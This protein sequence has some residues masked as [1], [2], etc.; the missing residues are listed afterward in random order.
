[1]Q[2]FPPS[3]QNDP[4]VVW[5]LVV[6]AME[7]RERS[8]VP[9]VG[10]S[11]DRRTLVHVG[12]VF[13]EENIKC[14]MCFICGCKHIYHHG[15]DKYGCPRSKGET[16]YRTD[17][18]QHLR[19][20]LVGTAEDDSSWSYNLSRKR[21]KRHFGDAVKTDEHFATE[22]WEWNRNVIRD[23]KA[24]D[25]ICNPEDVRRTAAC[26]HDDNTVCTK[27]QI[28]ICNEC[29]SLAVSDELIP[30]ALANDNYVG[31]AYRYF[32]E[33][34]VTWLEAT[35][36]APVFTG[37]INYYIEGPAEHRHH[38]MEEKVGRPDRA[39]GVRGSIFSFLL[40][41]EEIHKKLGEAVEQG[42]LSAWPMAP[43]M[44]AQ[45]VRVR[46]VR[47]PTEMINKFKELRIRAG[48]VRAIAMLYIENHVQDLA[49]R[50]GVLKI[51]RHHRKATVLQSLQAH[52]TQRVAAC[53]PATAFPDDVGGVLPEIKAMVEQ[54][55]A[56]TDKVPFESGFELKQSTMPDVS[57]EP[58]KLFEH[59]RPSLVVGESSSDGIH[60]EE[61]LAAQAFKT[62]AGLDIPMSTTFEKQWNSK[63]LPL[64]SPWA[65]KYACGG[66]EYPDLFSNWDTDSRS[67][68]IQDTWRRLAGEA[69]LLPGPYAQM[70]AT[71]PEMQL[72]GDWVLV[73]GAR[74]L[75]WRY[76]VLHSAFLE[77]KMKVAPGETSSI[78]G[79]GSG[80]QIISFIFLFPRFSFYG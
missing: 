51:H 25:L 71:R 46:L 5:R 66:A 8:N 80:S 78:G 1:M 31:Y 34:D 6:G 28:P 62:V 48:V 57:S 2:S 20:V 52:V 65:L 23:G 9:L 13:Y 45:V 67:L 26:K 44:V 18:S 73:P 29:W 55:E 42:D 38:L 49:D 59:E 50:P 16:D 70:L 56:Q 14:L 24:Q 47:G 15:F 40:P 77:C 39:Y 4:E 7:E 37:L 58:D 3:Q 60:D 63:Y 69:K 27:C 74:N 21:F 10:H 54:Q 68:T 11:T 35:V 12:E 53:Y 33:N 32:V 79:I 43:D 61:A 72:A 30:K 64:T 76:M 22:T 17:T 36:A 41:W 19:R 75:H